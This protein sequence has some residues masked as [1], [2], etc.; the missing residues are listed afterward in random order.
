M[1]GPKVCMISMIGI[2]LFCFPKSIFEKGDFSDISGYISKHDAHV[3][4]SKGLNE[5][6]ANPKT[7]QRLGW[8]AD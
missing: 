5:A 3:Q 6:M 2:D 4:P 8:N 1:V 7:L